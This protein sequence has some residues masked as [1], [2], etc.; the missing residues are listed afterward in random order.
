[1]KRLG[2]MI[3]AIVA[4]TLIATSAMPLQA[5]QNNCAA[6]N[7]VIERLELDFGESLAGGGLQTDTQVI[8]IWAADDTGTWTV[9]LTNADG[10]SCIMASGTNWHQNSPLNVVRGIAG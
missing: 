7:T 10:L 3:P 8:E 6:R 1:M 4:A 5:Q 9:L 2:N